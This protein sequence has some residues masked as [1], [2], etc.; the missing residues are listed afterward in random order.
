MLQSDKVMRAAMIVARIRD[1]SPNDHL[2]RLQYAKQLRDLVE[3]FIVEEVR[4][5]NSRSRD[6]KHY[7][8]WDKI[9]HVL[10]LSRSA[11]FT[12]YGSKK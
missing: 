5:A 8:S 4:K 11:T 3:E 9:G 7:M 10:D 2:S 1:S 6:D 12:R